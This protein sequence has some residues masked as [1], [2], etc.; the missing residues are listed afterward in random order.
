M[1]R[2][3]FLLVLFLLPA[4]VSAA[5]RVYLWGIRRSCQPS[6]ELTKAVQKALTTSFFEVVALSPK[7]TKGSC[8]GA[9][10]AALLKRSCGTV[11]KDGYIVGGLVE[12]SPV[13][14]KLRLWSHDLS[15]G[16]TIYHDD[17]CQGC[18]MASVLAKKTPLLVERSGVDAT[19]PNATPLYCTEQSPP[20]AERPPPSL[21]LFLSVFGKGSHRKD[22]QAALIKYLQG[23]AYQVSLV[24]DAN[25]AFPY[26]EL[27]RITAKDPGAQVLMVELQSGGVELSL[28]DQASGRTETQ[29]I[30]CPGCDKGELWPKLESGTSLLLARCFADECARITYLR[31]PADACKPFAEL[32]CGDDV[33]ASLV[34]ST[35][36][37]TTDPASTVDPKL[38]KTLKGIVWGAVAVSAIATGAV[39]GANYSSAGQVK[40]ENSD[41][42]NRL[43]PAVGFGIGATVLS[44]GVAIP[45]TI[46][47]TP[48]RD[49]LG[50]SATGAV[51]TLCPN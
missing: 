10:C 6:E 32:R 23:A 51:S 26:S 40:G 20:L 5:P 13:L 2:L 9:E 3:L 25:T 43:L 33:A 21:K 39:L 16:K 8:Q 45:T 18:D 34:S 36:P 28:F 49:T 31:P 38:A 37:R 41:I 42:G 7:L 44:L 17:W 46:L 15:T 14:G 24:E 47:L 27:K 50:T 1:S 12:P 35:A 11:S 48:R 30:D 19:V 22:T 4:P 29:N